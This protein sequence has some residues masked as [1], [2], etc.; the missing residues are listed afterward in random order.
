MNTI[1]TELSMSCL[2]GERGEDTLTQDK[3]GSIPW[4]GGHT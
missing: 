2:T 1:N 3:T 4:C